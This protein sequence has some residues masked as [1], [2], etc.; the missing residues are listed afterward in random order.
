M[1]SL[2]RGEGLPSKASAGIVAISVN[3][4]GIVPSSGRGKD[5]G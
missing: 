2:W 3:L 4:S 5:D 1:P